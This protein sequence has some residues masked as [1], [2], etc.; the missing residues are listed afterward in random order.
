VVETITE[1]TEIAQMR[2]D[3]ESAHIQVQQRE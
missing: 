2:I 1:G 3:K